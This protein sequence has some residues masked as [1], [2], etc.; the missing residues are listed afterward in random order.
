MGSRRLILTSLLV[1]GLIA[2][3]YESYSR[4]VLKPILFVDVDFEEVVETTG[5]WKG[6]Y[7]GYVQ[8]K[9]SRDAH[10]VRVSVNTGSATIR[11][12]FYPSASGTAY[13][14]TVRKGGIEHFEIEVY[15]TSRY[16]LEGSFSFG[17]EPQ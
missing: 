12:V 2:V 7:M 10:G 11:G 16:V 17:W 15:A 4:Y 13:I 8:N 5:G 3:G 1:L 9:G 6:T 14:G